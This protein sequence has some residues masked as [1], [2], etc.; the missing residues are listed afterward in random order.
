MK[1]FIV[2]AAIAAF[3]CTTAPAYAQTLNTDMNIAICKAYMDSEAKS[4]DKL[5]EDYVIAYR[6]DRQIALM[7]MNQCLGY[8]VGRHEALELVMRGK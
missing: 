7:A 8:I 2:F 5:M 3:A 6:G 1:K 4:S